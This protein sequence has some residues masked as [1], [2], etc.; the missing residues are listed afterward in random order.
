M[1]DGEQRYDDGDDTPLR[2]YATLATTF[3][4]G[5]GVFALTACAPGLRLPDTVPAWDVA[6]L[7]TATFKA[8]RLLTKDKVTSF[9]R[10]RSPGASGGEGSEVMDARAARACGGPSATWS[11]A[12]SAPPPGWPADWSAPTPSRP[13]PPGWSAPA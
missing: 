8:S 11:P 7:G 12:P 13:G 4:A 2:G 6:L 1:T 10:A 5:A 9:L 3:V